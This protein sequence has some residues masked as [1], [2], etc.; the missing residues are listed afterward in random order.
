MSKI[1]KDLT[2]LNNKKKTGGKKQN[3]TKKTSRGWV[4][5]F[6][7]RRNTNGQ[8]SHAKMLNITNYQRKCQLVSC[9]QLFVTLWTSPPDSSVHGKNTTR[10]IAISFFRGSSQNRDQTQVPYIAARF[11]TSEP[12]GRSNY[13]VT[14][15]QNC[16]ELSS[17]T[18]KNG[19]YQKDN[20]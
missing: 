12:P 7:Q 8:Q 18:C 3:K 6:C 1:Y 14:S 17:H 19:Y 2:Q 9:V 16:S 10:L 15:H 11:F 4:W 20:I 5:T 13:Q